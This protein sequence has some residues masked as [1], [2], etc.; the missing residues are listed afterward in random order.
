ML[1]VG[2]IVF[3]ALWLLSTCNKATVDIRM[4]QIEKVCKCKLQYFRDNSQ[5]SWSVSVLHPW[6]HESL[7]CL[8]LQNIFE[9]YN[10]SILI[11]EI[12]NYFF[13]CRSNSLQNTNIPHSAFISPKIINGK[14]VE[15]VSCVETQDN[16]HT[17][18]GEARN[19]QEASVRQDSSVSDKQRQ[20]I[21]IADSPSPAVSVITI[22]SD[23]DDEETSPRHSL[24]E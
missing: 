22:S 13:G 12:T 10:F 5:N 4:S 18:E 1:S 6:T 17:S 11:I 19:C 24:R 20:T 14:D 23:T 7:H 3:T 21:I 15:E 9:K 8:V 16:R 2:K